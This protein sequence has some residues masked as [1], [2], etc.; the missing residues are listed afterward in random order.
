MTET[1]WM[2][3]RDLVQALTGAPLNS[4]VG[5][6]LQ[7]ESLRRVWWVLPAHQ[8]E[9]IVTAGDAY[10]RGRA[11]MGLVD[12]ARSR[13]MLSGSVSATI[14]SLVNGLFRYQTD[15]FIDSCREV[16]RRAV[17]EWLDRLP[18]SGKNNH[19]PT[20]TSR[21]MQIA[22]QWWERTWRESENMGFSWAG[23]LNSVWL[24]A[25]NGAIAAVDDEF[26]F[27]LSHILR[28][29]TPPLFR[30][31]AFDPRWRS[32]TAVALAAGIYEDRAFDRLPILADA[33]EEAGCDHAD[34]LAHC[35]GPGPHAR[36]CW[37]VDLVLNKS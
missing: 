2:R 5:F 3:A 29:I 26:V 27:E 16:I 25:R 10:C 31:V 17:S 32:E 11:N 23:S 34:V 20:P 9:L 15:S 21:Y 30:T 4:T 1:E 6:R 22:H 12:L 35:R 8:F 19:Q 28:D 33:L 18:R 24:D 13:V 37:V 36:G 7:V 14:S